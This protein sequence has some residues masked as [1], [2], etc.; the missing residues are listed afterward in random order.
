MSTT[1]P[2]VPS[3]LAHPAQGRQR[4]DVGRRTSPRVRQLAV[5]AVGAGLVAL[6]GAALAV[7]GGTAD[8]ESS[9]L[10][11]AG[12]LVDW[13]APVV[14]LVARIAAVGTVGALLFAAVLVPGHRG[15]LSARGRWAVRTASGWALAWAVATAL[16]GLLALGRLVGMP[17]LSVP[18][19]VLRVYLGS[20]GPGR[21]VVVVAV[22]AAVLALAARR[23]SGVLGAR[24]LL[25]GAL[26]AVVV[27]AVLTGH[28]SA[29]D[30]HLVAVTTLAV[31]VAAASL[32][33]GGLAAL[34]GHGRR[35]P[36]L[37]VAAARFSRV[38][39]GCFLATGISGVLAAWL[40]L[41][42]T[43]AVVAALGTGYGWLLVGKT[44]GLAVLGLLGWQHRRRALPR[45]RAGRPHAFR[46]LAAGELLVMLATVALAVGL[47]ASPPPAA[48]IAGSTSAGSVVA[49]AATPGV[50]APGDPSAATVDPMAGHDH[51][52]LSVGVLVDT[53][54]FHVAGPVAPGSR[55]TVH[56][57]TDE[58]VTLTADDGSF[59]V[60]VPGHTLLTFLAPERPGEY[61]FT[62]RHSSTYR[63]VLV[64]E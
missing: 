27:P 58:Q 62:S 59:D 10:G 57:G 33:V 42:G 4:E 18:W 13:G 49:G 15:G 20:T 32:W 36:V 61:R 9:G 48:A 52:E 6:L 26:T 11:R 2:G 7:G 16:G 23:C 12:A 51:G 47:A 24:L 30:D 28:S 55:V 29:A 19:S 22:G 34:L 54:R 21:A 35:E 63:D 56:N 31:H 3:A 37:T 64:V 38:A 5:L 53:G 25:A 40:V 44:L 39:L 50:P 14:T 17:P 45:L 43:G 60:D 46:R 8:G 41:G 1:A